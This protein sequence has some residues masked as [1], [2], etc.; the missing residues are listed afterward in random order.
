MTICADIG[1]I[2]GSPIWT[3]LATILAA[4]A[5]GVSIWLYRRDRTRKSLAYEVKQV[6]LV[7]VHQAAPK[8]RIKIL[9]DDEEIK[10]VHLIE[11]QIENN[12]NVPV[13]VED[14]EQAIVID[15]GEGATA[16]T[17]DISKVT[18]DNL[19][20]EVRPDGNQVEIQP[21]LLNP[22]DCMTLKIFARDFGGKVERRYR[23][24]GISKMDDAAIQRGQPV[25]WRWYTAHSAYSSAL[26]AAVISTAVA[27]SLIAAIGWLGEP[28]KNNSAVVTWAGERLCGQVLATSDRRIVLQLSGGGGIRAIRIGDVK[29]INDN[30]C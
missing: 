7:S 9:F 2:A 5:I 14:F 6:E 1:E 26:L 12:G 29:S 11:A 4:A 30:S 8:G 10:H 22:G 3:V 17:A 23:I 25:L 18:P 28:D 27:A 15:L 20:V 13:T 19:E 21:L 24:V 16:L